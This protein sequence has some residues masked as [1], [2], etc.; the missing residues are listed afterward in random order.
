VGVPEL[1]RRATIAAVTPPNLLASPRRLDAAMG[2]LGLAG[3][4]LGHSVLWNSLHPLLLPILVLGLVP[5]ERKNGVLGAVTFVGL[6]VALLVQ[7]VVGSISDR[8]GSRWGRRRPFVLGGALA[9][10]LLVGVLTRVAD[11]VTLVV[12][13]VGLQ[14]FSNVSMGAY[15][16]LIPDL[17]PTARH[18]AAAGARSFAEV[19]G[20]LV[21]AL[22]VGG[23][24]HGDDLG[25]G[26]VAVVTVLLLGTALTCLGV[27]EP[28]ERP[29]EPSGHPAG[30]GPART[31]ILLD[32]FRFDPRHHPAFSWMLLGRFCFVL[33][34]STI[35]AFAL[36]YVRDVVRP[37]DYLVVWRGMAGGIALAVL[38]VAYPSGALADRLGRRPIILAAGV[39]AAAG[40]LALALAGTPQTTMPFALLIGLGAGLFLS[41]GWALATDLVPP[42]QAGRFMGLTNLATA[43]G[44]AVARLNGPM[45]DALEAVRPALGYQAMLLLAAALFAAGGLLVLKVRS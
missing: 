26:F 29:R 5:E 44:A 42:E 7:P 30:P 18:G 43:G 10:A 8:A 3:Y 45:I 31:G 1:P 19:L 36:Y 2:F 34:L 4:Q 35:Q 21:A 37:P 22:A 6:V 27:A 9:A 11:L 33:A 41:S 14:A 13:Y 39:L 12:V 24:V 32:A 23:L 40:A 38:V 16:G 25:P 17:V 15:Q 20:L 28:K